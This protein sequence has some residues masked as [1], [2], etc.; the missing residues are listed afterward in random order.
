MKRSVS[1]VRLVAP[2]M[3]TKRFFIRKRLTLPLPAE[4]NRSQT[5]SQGMKKN[6]TGVALASRSMN[7][8]YFFINK[9][10]ILQLPFH[11][12]PASLCPGFL[13]A[14][15]CMCCSNFS[16]YSFLYLLSFYLHSSVFQS[17]RYFSLVCCTVSSTLIFIFHC[18]V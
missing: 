18:C 5:N 8:E 7:T 6:V 2:S 16:T 9:Q 13:F 10:L 14:I 3:N 15:F 4:E 11:V 12:S 17:C 1:R